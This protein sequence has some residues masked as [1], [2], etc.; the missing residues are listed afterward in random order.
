M[1]KRA[2][3]IK[4]YQYP[5]ERITI[6]FKYLTLSGDTFTQL[7]LNLKEKEPDLYE[8]I[9]VEF[10]EAVDRYYGTNLKTR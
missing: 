4:E 9:K 7:M 2:V 10:E 5:E 8:D 6:S 3:Q 1:K